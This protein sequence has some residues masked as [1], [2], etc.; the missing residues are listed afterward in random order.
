ME[1]AL[2][3]KE[4]AAL[5]GVRYG[6]VY[7]RRE[8]L[9]FFQIGSVWRVRQD[10]LRRRL[11]AKSEEKSPTRSTAPLIP[12]LDSRNSHATD[13]ATIQEQGGGSKSIRGTGGQKEKSGRT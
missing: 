11:S 2:M 5:L 1:K 6:I 8:E 13:Y 7:A 9:G 10:D 3:L 4:A 12:S